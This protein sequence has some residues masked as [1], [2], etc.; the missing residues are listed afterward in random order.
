M[1]YTAEE[2]AEMIGAFRR[3]VA[4]VAKRMVVSLSSG[5]AW[6]MLGHTVFNK[7]RE[8]PNVE[9]YQGIGFASRP[10][11]GSKSAEGIVIA[12]GGVNNPALVATRDE[13]VRAASAGD[14]E[15]DEAAVFN[16]TARVRVKKDGTVEITSIGGVALRLATYDDVKAI[17]DDLDGHSHLYVPYPGGAAG[18]P[19]ATTG[20]PAVT[21][22]AGTSVIKGE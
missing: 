11:A 1:S 22:P 15:D 14:L 13:A 16:T 10:P 9:A 2:F 6:Q 19:V 12:V 7:R 21:D 3:E 17:R 4:A 18:T 5:P 8:A 20:N